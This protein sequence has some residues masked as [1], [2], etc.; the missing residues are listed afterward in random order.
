VIQL[1]HEAHKN[2]NPDVSTAQ[3]LE[4]LET[5]NSRWQDTFK[6]NSEAKKALVIAGKRKGTLRLNL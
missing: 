6:S 3:I 4:R 2:G 5:S 1:L